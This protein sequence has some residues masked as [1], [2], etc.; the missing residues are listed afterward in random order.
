MSEAMWHLDGPRL[1]RYIRE[2]DARFQSAMRKALEADRPASPKPRPKVLRTGGRDVIRIAPTPKAYM[3]DADRILHE[4][5][6][7][8]QVTRLEVLGQQ[9]SRPLVAARHEA[10]YRLSK[11]TTM[12]F[13][14]I[15]RKM[16]G[17]DHSTV[18]HGVRMHEAKLR[19]E[20]YVKPRGERQTQGTTG[21]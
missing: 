8:H 12:S 18:I 10:F 4:V 3:T 7:Q 5:C 9:R 1:T 2:Q 20:V 21:I 17:K 11:E 13:P 14:R 6:E 15:G 19:G 16:G